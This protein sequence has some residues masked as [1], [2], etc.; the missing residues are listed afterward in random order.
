MKHNLNGVLLLDKPINFTS[1]AALQTV[2]KLLKASKVGHTGSL[3]PIASG[4]LPLCFGD[5]TKFSQFLLEADKRYLVTGKLG[6][7]TAS[8]DSETAVIVKRKVAGVSAD[9]IAAILAKFRGK[10]S[11]IPPMYSAIKYKGQPLYKLVRK[12]VEVERAPRAVNI[13]ELRLLS[14]DHDLME[15]DIHC[16]KGTYVRTLIV[17]IGEALGYG[18]HVVALRRLMVGSYQASQMVTLERLQYLVAHNEYQELNKLLLPIET[19]LAKMPEVFLTS[20][21]V[22]YVLSGQPV[23]VPGTAKEGGWVKLKSKDG[24]FLGVGEVMSDGRMAPRKIV[25]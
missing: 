21:M 13:Y 20:D 23:L 2:K 4:M 1:N 3:D 25:R 16:S 17:D 18:A 22:H 24:K 11:Q 7:T 12:G 5:A 15:F 6:E 8:G 9:D 14:L 10:I 19:M